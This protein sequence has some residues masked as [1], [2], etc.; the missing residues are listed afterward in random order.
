MSRNDRA[1]G[2]GRPQR[3]P[4]RGAGSPRRDEVGERRS[5]AEADAAPRIPAHVSGRELDARLRREVTEALGDRGEEVC[6]RLVAAFAALDDGDPL[7]AA[8]HAEVARR[9]GSRLAVV[10]EATGIVAYRLG[11]YERAS[12]DLQAARRIGGS[13][14]SVA[15]LADC[16]R[17]L[18]RPERA[19]ELVAGTSPA[20]LD[21]AELAELLIVAAGARR[22]LG[23]AEAAVGTLRTPLLDRAS[24]EAWQERLWFA[25][26]EALVA[27]GREAE[28]R[29]WLRR[30][31]THPAAA[32]TADELVGLSRRAAGGAADAGTDGAVGVGAFVDLDELADAERD[33]A[34]SG[35][36]AGTAE[37]PVR[38]QRT[39]EDP[40]RHLRSE[41]R[42]L[43][44]HEQTRGDRV[45][46]VGE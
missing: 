1:R 26:G 24:N 40:R 22:D 35:A 33:R 45:E 25:Y 18:G 32:T 37:S 28:G 10:R 6:R 15:V 20:G 4:S 31:A 7:A 36:R 12:R 39:D 34:R 8:G 11:D 30:A 43:D 13:T 5:V 41:R 27:A 9:R 14:A 46:D 44:R 29:R 3:T 23:Q 21:P 17:A 16:E 19:L 2:T 42:G 38:R